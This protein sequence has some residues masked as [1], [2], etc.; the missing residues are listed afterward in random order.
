MATSK[1]RAGRA[2]PTI[3][4]NAL[5]I[6]LISAVAA[7]AGLATAHGDDREVR[8]L[9]GRDL[10]AAGGL[11]VISESD[12]DSV[13]AAGETVELVAPTREDALLA[14]RRVEV[15]ARVGDDAYL[16]GETVDVSGPVAGRVVAA[17]ETVTLDSRSNTG[18]AVRLFG[19]RIE[20]AGTVAGDT[21]IAAE[22]VRLSG[23]FSG[24]VTVTAETVDIAPAARFGGM[25]ITRAP[26]EPAVPSTAAP[27]ERRRYEKWEP[28]EWDWAWGPPAPWHALFGMLF[29]AVL[30]FPLSL[31]VAGGILLAAAGGTMDRIAEIGRS[32]PGGSIGAGLVTLAV[33]AVAALLLMITFI[34]APLGILLFLA[35]PLILMLGY[36]AGVLTLALGA[37]RSLGKPSPGG[38]GR[39]GLLALGLFVLAIVGLIP[40]VGVIVGILVTLAGLGAAMITLRGRGPAAAGT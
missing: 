15:R 20:I 39:F 4:R 12:L 32:R 14:G 33:W 29:G 7:L 23:T 8:R 27:P 10:A 36:V 19:R 24:D 40:V 13:F 30:V 3:H 1:G 9:L 28:E 34:G 25:L 38:L 21:W 2:V 16:A 5:A 26:V 22:S 31:L 11:V 6:V 17:G 37:W 35:L 18:G